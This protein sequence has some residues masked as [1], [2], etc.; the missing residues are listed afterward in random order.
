MALLVALCLHLGAGADPA[1]ARNRA[2]YEHVAWE[3][4]QH[5]QTTSHGHMR[6]QETLDR[7][8][9]SGIRF[10]TISNY[11]PSAPLCPMAGIRDGQFHVSQ[12]HPV[13]VDGK[14]KPGPFM[15]NDIIMD[16]QSGWAGELPEEYRGRLPFKAGDAAF[17]KVPGDILEAPNAEHHSFT[18]TSLHI[19]APGAAFAS[20]TFDA[21]SR[22]KLQD[23]GYRM[24]MARPWREGFQLVLD[25][26]VVPD[27]GGITL[28]HPVWSK[29]T[30]ESVVEMLD[31][32]A[33]VL[34]I[35]VFNH[36]CVLEREDKTCAANEVLWD[37][38]LASGRQCY[39][40]FV[41]DHR[42]QVNAPWQG[43]NVLLVDAFTVEDCLRAYRTGAFYGALRGNGLR[44]TSIVVRDGEIRV[45]TN[46]ATSIEFITEK[47]VAASL[48]GPEG[49][50][51]LP[52]DTVF[53]RVRA[54]DTAGETLYSQ[55]AMLRPAE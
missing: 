32:D 21:R 36:G 45:V 2:P 17:T 1:S 8:Y 4:V 28:N 6:R 22:F 24:G 51:A 41:P 23:H 25:S 5:I 55:P 42:A 37:R 20:G 16:A 18:D 39:G 15:W 19:C 27:G 3:S 44:F 40:F 9:V 12:D 7:M 47:G 49:A 33:R 54:K 46:R 26:L 13:I 29:L 34:G 31:F 38:I 14:P 10:F 35:E 48:D 43:R 50:Y 53:V 52:D 30:Y 11:Y